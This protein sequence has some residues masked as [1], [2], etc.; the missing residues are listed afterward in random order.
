MTSNIHFEYKSKIEQW[1][2]HSSIR[3]RPR[4]FIADEESIEHVFPPA[5]QPILVH[6][7]L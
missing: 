7:K 5:R 6:P 4:R 1:D 2:K 3:S